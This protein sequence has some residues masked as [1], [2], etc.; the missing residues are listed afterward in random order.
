MAVKSLMKGASLL[1]T[2][3][4]PTP[5]GIGMML[6]GP[7]LGGLMGGKRPKVSLPD[8]LRVFHQM[9]DTGRGSNQ[10][11]SGDYSKQY[12]TMYNTEVFE[13]ELE[14]ATATARAQKQQIEDAG[15]SYDDYN[16]LDVS[17]A[18]GALGNGQ[19]NAME[20]IQ[21]RRAST[22][23]FNDNIVY[24]GGGGGAAPGAGD[25]EMIDVARTLAKA[26]LGEDPR[27]SNEDYG[28]KPGDGR[29]PR[30]KAAG[31]HPLGTAR[32]SRAAYG[33]GGDR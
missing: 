30:R 18:R 12:R 21:T 9:R 3:L 6:A 10:E 24:R 1:K 14:S 22:K 29:A 20:S 32:H 5:L 33:G 15:M 2:A 28:R 19:A 16:P 26:K 11:Q 7:L 25:P 13:D 23:A 27:A 31:A 4:N 17:F 8:D